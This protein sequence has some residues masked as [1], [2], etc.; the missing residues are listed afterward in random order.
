[1][2]RGS[3]AVEMVAPPPMD[4]LPTLMLPGKLD[5]LVGAMDAG[6]SAGSW[7]SA[8]GGLGATTGGAGGVSPTSVAETSFR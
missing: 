3:D 5:T 4:P 1:M 2:T 7:A 8:T 6:A